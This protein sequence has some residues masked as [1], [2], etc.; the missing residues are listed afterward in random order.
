MKT[1]PKAVSE[2]LKKSD[3]NLKSV[4]YFVFH[5][6]NKFMLDRLRRKIKIPSEKFCI[7]LEMCGNTVSSTIPIALENAKSKNRIK[8]GDKVMLVGFGVGYS[9]AATM[10]QFV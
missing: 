3:Q 9:W 7:H 6:A 4:D 2:L 1:I 8:A 5:Q 10:I